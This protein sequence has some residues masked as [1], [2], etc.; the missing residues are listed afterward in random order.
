MAIT[1]TPAIILSM[2]IVI[3][4]S[5]HHD[6]DHDA[7]ISSVFLHRGGPH[8]LTHGRYRCGCH[9]PW[10]F[11]AN[12]DASHAGPS[13]WPVLAKF[14]QQQSGHTMA[15]A[16]PNRATSSNIGRSWSNLG[17]YVLWRK[18]A[19]CLVMCTVVSDHAL[20]RWTM[21]T[22]VRSRACRKMCTSCL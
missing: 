14:G 21:C 6:T 4:V 13:C 12:A 18:Y 9:Y 15:R 2:S 17:I 3:M 10:R 8:V 16:G 19:W 22:D 1:M 7:G 20:C 11:P 5:F